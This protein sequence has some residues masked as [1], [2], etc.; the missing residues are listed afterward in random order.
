MR[1][2]KILRG[3][4]LLMLVAAAIFVAA[5]LQNPQLGTAIRVGE[6][7]LGAEVWRVCYGLYLL[8]MAGLFGASFVVR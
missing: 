4:S 6:L 1:K 2:R 7:Y 8:V 3:I 5:A